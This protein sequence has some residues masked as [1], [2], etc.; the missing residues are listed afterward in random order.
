LRREAVFYRARWNDLRRRGR[1]RDGK[2][3]FA[4]DRDRKAS[5]QAVVE[6]RGLR[7]GTLSKDAD[8]SKQVKGCVRAE[9]KR[10]KGRSA[11][12]RL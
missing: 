3:K 4:D 6:E 12:G 9:V 10:K 8:A 11:R 7:T 1:T 5:Q 2:V